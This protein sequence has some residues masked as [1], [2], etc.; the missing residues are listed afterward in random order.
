MKLTSKLTPTLE[1]KQIFAAVKGTNTITISIHAEVLLT[2]IKSLKQNRD[3]TLP[4]QQ[5]VKNMM[6]SLIVMERH[7]ANKEIL[8]NL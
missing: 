3:W 6:K 2:R 5:L 1:I 4:P 8:S 7:L